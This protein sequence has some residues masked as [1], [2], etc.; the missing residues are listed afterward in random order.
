MQ[1]M[2]D[3]Y[4]ANGTKH[5]CG[6]MI[7]FRQGL[8]VTVLDSRMDIRGRYVMLKVIV[9]GEELYLFNVYGPTKPNEKESFFNTIVQ[10]MSTFDINVND[11]VVIA[12]DWNTILDKELDKKGGRDKVEPISKSMTVSCT[13]L[14]SL[15]FS[16]LR[17]SWETY[18]V[19]FFLATSPASHIRALQY[20]I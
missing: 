4:F 19:S 8:G 5:S 16:G 11:K 20:L 12:G 3:N 6:T 7:M 14:F 13:M 15:R 1:V 10:E 17:S 2:M 9:E 18:S